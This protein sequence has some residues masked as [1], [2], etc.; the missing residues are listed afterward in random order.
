MPWSFH[1][2]F[3]RRLDAGESGRLDKT[4]NFLTAEFLAFRVLG[5]ISTRDAP[6]DVTV[7]IVISFCVFPVVSL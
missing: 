1:H 4:Q 5:V 7:T 2:C 6:A 3:V